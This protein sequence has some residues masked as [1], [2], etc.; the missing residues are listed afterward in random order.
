MGLPA[1]EE[2]A[3]MPATASQRVSLEVVSD[4]HDLA[5]LYRRADVVI[6]P[7]AFGGGTKNKTLEA[8]GWSRPIVGSPQAFTGLPDELRG[9]AYVQTP[10]DADAMA[11]ALARLAADAALRERIG[12]AARTY[13][14]AEHS[15]ARVDAAID[16]VYERVLGAGA[17]S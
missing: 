2:R 11:G 7:L 9:V 13:V 17:R 6:V 12:R 4:P 16:E 15:Q 1:S 3:T 5:P 10:L 14:L 8:M